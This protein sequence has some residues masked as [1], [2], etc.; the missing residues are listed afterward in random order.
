M[1]TA[2]ETGER[3]KARRQELK[4]TQD[5]LAEK[6]GYHGKSA[7]SH[8]EK[9][10]SDMSQSKIVAIAA[11]LDTTVD[12][13]LGLEDGSEV[14][15]E[16]EKPPQRWF[17][18]PRSPEPEVEAVVNSLDMILLEELIPLILKLSSQEKQHIIDYI[19]ASYDVDVD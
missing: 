8:I 1:F 9:G 7:I 14:T 11:A 17:N 2:K 10:D 16:M 12:Y 3:I 13:I 19:K 15:I 5:Q 18:S 6:I 4:M